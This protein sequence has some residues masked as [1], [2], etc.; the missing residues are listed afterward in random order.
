MKM[1]RLRVQLMLAFLLPIIIMLASGVF[2]FFAVS[3]IKEDLAGSSLFQAQ[4]SR[5]Q[6]IVWLDE[7]LTQS[8]RNYIFTSDTKWKTRYNDSA[9]KLDEAIG[10]AIENANS[11]ETRK[12]FERQD[13]ANLNLIEL[14]TEA[15]ALV[16][17]GKNGEALKLIEGDEYTKWKTIYTQTIDDFLS[18]SET[19][20][21]AFQNKLE[22]SV[23]QSTV[24]S[25][26]IIMG[27][28]LIGILLFL[29]AFIMSGRIAHPI[30]IITEQADKISKGDLQVDFSIDSANEIGRLAGSFRNMV[31]AFQYKADIIDQIAG[32]DL[33]VDVQ[34]ASERD[35]LGQ[36]LLIMKQSLNDL[37]GQVNTAVEQVTS[38]ADQ[39][40]QSSQNLSQEATQQASS[41]QEIS[42]SI[43]EVNSQ[44][45]QNAE[46][47][48]EAYAIAKQAT[49]D[50][51]E[52]NN[53]MQQLQD[54]IA[55]INASS[56]K[57]NQVVKVIDDLSFQISL[58]ALNAN[59]EAARAGKYGKGFTVVAEEVRNLAVKSAD[60]VKETTEMVGETVENIKKGTEAADATAKQLS[61]IVEGTGKAADFLRE[62]EEASRQQAQAIAQITEG[63][64]QIDD[65]TQASTAGAEQ[66]ASVSEELASQAKQLRTMV[67]QFKLDTNGASSSS[68]LL[69]YRMNGENSTEMVPMRR[70]E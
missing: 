40:S 21:E 8:L 22:N 43:N 42:S 56:E 47:A 62:I 54:S 41:L 5:A 52:G 19:G 13:E 30:K 44:S 2:S 6:T 67:S 9:G 35:R 70:E 7:V 63:L 11:E 4:L 39:V 66:S 48:S 36:S 34:T 69:S 12:I 45:K 28:V 58:L 24:I 3:G 32:K 1:K 17:E 29:F 14:E 60:S 51:E 55:K 15:F 27:T 26:Y 16:D 31:T 23:Q 61:A 33:S 38:G 53:K 64:D 50:A 10:S 65:S 18:N 59:V 25:L 20:V 68:R 49:T 46:N 57:I 37:L